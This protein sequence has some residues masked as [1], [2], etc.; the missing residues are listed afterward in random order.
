MEN[1]KTIHTQMLAFQKQ[2]IVIPRK[3]K[4]T[5]GGRSYTYATL[6]DLILIVKPILLDLGLYFT[7]T[8]ND[9]NITTSVVH[10]ETGIAIRSTLPL[11]TP[12][13]SQ[14]LGSRITYFRRYELISLLGLTTEDDVDG[15]GAPSKV[16]A[17]VKMPEIHHPEVDVVKT[18]ADTV[19]P[20]KS[21]VGV[22]KLAAEMKA[23]DQAAQPSKVTTPDPAAQTTQP[24]QSSL[25]E[26]PKDA[27]QIS[28]A[29]Q[30]A[31][32]AI[33]S[34]QN[35]LAL[36]TIDS[37]IETSQRLT[38]EE[39]AQL[40]PMVAIKMDEINGTTTG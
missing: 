14:D 23:I 33:D 20:V 7:Q 1:T 12:S 21:S 30:K 28:P 40:K 18:I 39:K 13:S 32:S 19:L 26:E 35:I 22:D 16:E 2:S 31:I 17:T 5:I 9:G 29:M 6:D 3:G 27:I 8:M 4:N 25:L 38:P 37:N 11:G 36:K 34:C 10:A 15:T 24:M